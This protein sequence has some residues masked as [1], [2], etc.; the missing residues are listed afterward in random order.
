[1]S[2]KILHIIDSDGIYGAEIMLLNL[3]EEQ[4][5]LGLNPILLSIESA[6]HDDVSDIFVEAEKNGLTAN[7]MGLNRG[8]S[9]KGANAIIEHAVT[10]RVDIIH[11][12]SYK[13]NILLG[14]LS[15]KIRKLPVIS[16]VHGWTSVNFFSKIGIYTILD[17]MAIK[18]LDG[19]VY[20]NPIMDNVIGH[21][22]SY[23]IANGI[24]I[25]EF[26]KNKIT[27]EFLIKNTEKE[28]I[29]G[30]ISRLSEE[31]GIIYLLKAAQEI[32]NKNKY[33]K[34]AIIGDGPLK[35]IFKSFIKENGL[36]NNISIMGYKA[37]AF[38][39]LKNFDVFVLPSLT[40]GLPITI[41]EAMQAEIP[42]VGTNVG[43]VP[44][45]LG[46]GKY[47][48]L[49]K[50]GNSRLLVE[51]ISQVISSP[52]LSLKIAKKARKYMLDNYSSYKMAVSYMNVYKELIEKKI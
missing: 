43:A 3:M 28:F 48:L 31:K 33:V 50:S 10:Q 16:T 30:A 6:K 37:A 42:I 40:E 41:L 7:R 49:V 47:G 34:L 4:V 51:A 35:Q 1:M 11:S 19:V 20:V 26:D 36:N 2:M 32:I 21:K 52:D 27:D 17:K 29:I 22:N 13:S 15:H 23:H 8:F 14:F 38:K 44:D 5:K 12:H 24:R 25:H 9:L 45:V 46:Y 18:K 39:Y